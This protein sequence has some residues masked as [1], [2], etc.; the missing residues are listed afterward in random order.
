[1]PDTQEDITE[2]RQARRTG[3]RAVAGVRGHTPALRKMVAPRVFPVSLLRRGQDSLLLN[4]WINGRQCLLTVD[5]GASVSIIRSDL[6]SRDKLKRTPIPYRLKTATGDTAPVHG[7]L[8]SEVRIGTWTL[9]QKFL[10]ADI[11]DEV[12]LGVDIM[13]QYG[14]VID[15]EGQVLRIKGE[16]VAL[17]TPDQLEVPVMQVVVSESVSIPANHEQ[18]VAARIMGDPRGNMSYLIEPD[19][20][21]GLEKLLIARSIAKVGE[22]VPVRVANLDSRTRVLKQGDPIASCEPVSWVGLYESSSPSIHTEQRLNPNLEQLL[23]RSQ[24]NLTSEEMEEVTSFLL[25]NQD[26]FSLGDTDLGRTSIVYHRINTGDTEPIRQAPRRLPLA[27]QEEAE[28]MIASMMEGGVIEPSASPWASPVVLV[29]KKDGQ[30]RFC[31]DYRK[32]NDVTKKDSYPLPRIDDTLDTLSGT[33]WFSTLDLKSGYWQVE[34][35]P[36]DKEKTAFSTGSGLFQFT[37][38]PFGLCN[39]PATFERL[40]ELVLHSLTWKTCLVYLDDIIV[41]G[42]TVKEHLKNLQDVFDRLR[43]AQLKLSPKKCFLFQHEVTFLGHIVSQV[44]VRTDPEKIRSVKEWPRPENKHDVRSFLGLCT[45]YRRFVPGFAAIAKPLHELTEERR[46]FLWTPTC[47]TSFQDLKKALCTSPIL[48]Y[49][50]QHGDYILDTDASGRGLGAVLSQ[51]QDG[52]ERVIAYYSK[53]LSK[54]ES[55]YCVTRRE[56]LAL[57]KSFRHFHK[58]LYGRRFLLRT[59][60]AALKWLLQFKNP[61]GQLAR[62]IEQIQ[63]YDCKIEHRKGRIHSNADALSRRPCKVDCNH[64]KRAEK[65]EGIEDIRRTTI[66]NGEDKW[67][68]ASLKSAQHQ[69]PDLGPIISWMEKGTGRPSWQEV[70]SDRKEVK[71]YWAQWDSLRLVDG[72]LMRA[73]ESPNG[74]VVKMQLLLPK[75]LVAEVLKEIHDGTSGGH[76][77]V[78]KT[79]GKTRLHYY[80][81]KC[82]Q[83]VEAWCRKCETC[84]AR[85]RPQHCSRGK[86]QAYNVGAPFERIA[87]DIAGPFPKTKDGNRY[88]LVVMDYFSKWPEAYALPNQE[89]TTIADTLVN[90]FIC[91]FGVPMELHSDQGRNFESTVFQEVCRLLGINK[92]RTTALH[93]QS[94]GMV[95]RFNRTLEEHLAKVVAEHQQD[96][97]QHI[98]LFLMAYRAAIHDSTGQTPASIVF[99]QELRLPCDIKFGHPHQESTSTTDYVNRLEERMTFIHDE[100]R[101]NLRIATNRM[102]TRYDMKANSAGYHEGDLVWLYN[103]QR[104]KGRCPKLQTAW[105]GPYEVLKRLNDVVY[106]I[107][108]G[109]RGRMKVVH[110]DRLKGYAGRNELPVRD[111]QV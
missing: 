4:G 1:M 25:R 85:K 38:L 35:H 26:V 93:P 56:L 31:V 27:K 22:V 57:V 79:L 73:W 24:D 87:I 75:S 32:L 106:R 7:W 19:M 51:V 105:E 90:N 108:R 67:D 40:M 107:Q 55:N 61:E 98:Q 50:R 63:Q 3:K 99:G 33:R 78:N 34:L 66:T 29:A 92:T 91:R 111:E 110:L 64:C 14:F 20:T 71:A 97:D 9:P 83:D 95:E 76:L 68:N 43:H 44:G 39:A 23:E 41:V 69:D 10:V 54:P 53:V 86:M 15:M 70:S 2:R 12:I 104:R 96:W 89:A 59:D 77:G 21:L 48:A 18:I 81:L 94:D 62:W 80:W 17:F 88:I 109:K 37:V 82:R 52:N 16:E 103:P 45:Y 100:A 47:E 58:Y 8:E 72:L 13:N 101:R 46:Q 74:K 6:V 42:N 5:T 84:S 30:L 102:K 60:H 49:P 36:E 11:T 65:N 28:K